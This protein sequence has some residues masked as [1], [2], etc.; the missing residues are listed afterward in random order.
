MEEQIVVCRE[1]RPALDEVPP[2]EVRE[3]GPAASPLLVLDA[4]DEVGMHRRHGPNQAGANLIDLLR[5]PSRFQGV[6]E[7]GVHRIREKGAQ[8]RV[9]MHRSAIEGRVAE[10]VMD[11]DAEAVA[12][13]EMSGP[14]FRCL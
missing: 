6:F 10:P 9:A 3:E 14:V 1:D 2:Y 4:P 8:P 7:I 13:Q 12:K 5:G 11:R